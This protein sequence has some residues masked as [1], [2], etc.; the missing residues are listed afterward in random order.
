MEEKILIILENMQKD[1]CNIK[2]DIS[3]LT[4]DMSGV[5]EDISGLKVDM[6]GV[7]EDI[8][9]LK[10]DIKRLDDKTDALKEDIKRLDDKTDAFNLKMDKS[11]KE[12]SDEIRKV[13]EYLDDEFKNSINDL[14]K[15]LEKNMDFLETATVKNLSDIIMLKKVR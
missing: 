2:E 15:G 12:I 7:K 3:S 1:I 8:S 6:S 5:K 13:C 11:S 10:E 9:G 14:K 4:V